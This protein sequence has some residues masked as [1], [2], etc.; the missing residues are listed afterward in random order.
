MT[1]KVTQVE[2][3]WTHLKS[4]L[5]V[6]DNCSSQNS[7]SLSTSPKRPNNPWKDSFKNSSCNLK[8]IMLDELHSIQESPRES[9]NPSPR[10][11][12]KTEVR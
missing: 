1:K 7:V 11:D 2:K 12:T 5:V 8:P 3:D 6:L 10:A 9:N 4:C